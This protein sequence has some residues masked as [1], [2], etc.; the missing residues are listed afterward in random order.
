MRFRC[1]R[2]VL[3]DALST[4]SRAVAARGAA[5]PVLS[6]VRL[7]A[8]GA[9]LRASGT[10]LDLSIQVEADVS[11]DTDGVTVVPA[12]LT[13]DIA[14]SLDPGAVLFEVDEEEARI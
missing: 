3:V 13:T 11:T 4:V 1:E 2:D 7:A 9:K 10:D 8:S 14:R 5:L 12:R 6:G